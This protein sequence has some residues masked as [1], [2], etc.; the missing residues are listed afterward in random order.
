MVR[1][2]ESLEAVQ[3]YVPG[4]SSESKEQAD[5]ALLASNENPLPPVPSVQEAM[6]LAA[7]GANRYPDD[8]AAALRRRLAERSGVPA[9]WV[10]LGGGSVELCLQAQLATVDPGGEVVFAWPS[11]IAYPIHTALVGGRDVRVPLRDHTHDLDAMLE[12]VTDRTRVVFLCNPNNPTSTAVRGAAVRSFIEAVPD[13]CLVVLDEAYLEFDRTP[14]RVDGAALVAEHANLLVLRT[15]SKAYALAGV[16]VGYGLSQPHITAQL[17]KTRLTFGVSSVAQAGALASLEPEAEAEVARRVEEVV[18]AR[19]ELRA[20]LTD[21]GLDVPV[22]QA[23]FVYA[24]TGAKSA[25]FVQAMAAADV[26]VRPV[27]DVGVRITVG[28]AAEN[29]RFLDA[30]RAWRTLRNDSGSPGVQ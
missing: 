1:W 3:P 18:A 28:T 17:G 29:E 23:N 27:G 16:R 19:A 30:A 13:D 20:A 22:S 24:A 15:F 14:D 12:A 25:D 10:S 6:A 11:F 26:L 9:D 4:T 7:A 8:D 5:L 21:L 2:R